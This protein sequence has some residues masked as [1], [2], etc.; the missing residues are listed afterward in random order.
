MLNVVK[1]MYKCLIFNVM[2]EKLM[3][4][5]KKEFGELNIPNLEQKVNEADFLQHY[6]YPESDTHIGLFR[7][8]EIYF[9]L[10]SI[11]GRNPL[12]DFADSKH[13]GIMAFAEMIYHIRSNQ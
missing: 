6:F 1:L 5:V 10:A 7:L 12:M 11:P 2:K 13:D 8:K 4:K 3:K 9:V